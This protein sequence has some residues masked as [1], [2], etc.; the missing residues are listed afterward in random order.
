MREYINAILGLL[1]KDNENDLSRQAR[2]RVIYFYLAG[3]APEQV[4]QELERD[5]I[6]SQEEEHFVEL[7]KAMGET[8]SE[9][10]ATL[11]GYLIAHNERT[12]RLE[13]LLSE[14][15]GENLHDAKEWAEELEL[16]KERESKILR[17]SQEAERAPIEL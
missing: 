6:I 16:L 2:A 1:S 9:Q 7:I 8:S 12:G 3:F 5:F 15:A 14:Y 17:L 10:R 4:L 11:R 13:E